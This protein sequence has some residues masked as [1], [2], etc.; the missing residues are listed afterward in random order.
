MLNANKLAGMVARDL[1][2]MTDPIAVGDRVLYRGF[3]GTCPGV[4]V[5]VFRYA[6]DDGSIF[7]FT[8]DLDNGR[9]ARPRPEQLRKLTAEEIEAEHLEDLEF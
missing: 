1:R 8:V 4:V 6:H 7:E 5:D 3:F 9:R 2:Q